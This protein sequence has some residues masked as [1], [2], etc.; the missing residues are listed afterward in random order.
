MGR[1][2]K[3]LAEKIFNEVYIDKRLVGYYSTPNFICEYIKKRLIEIKYDGKAVFDPCCGR[4]EMLVPFLKENIKSYGIDII[5][6]KSS[7]NCC[8]QNMDFIRFFYKKI[9][10]ISEFKGLEYDYYVLNPPYNCHEVEYIRDNRDELKVIFKEVGIHNMYGM[11]IS[12][13]IDLAKEGAVIGIITND[14]FLTEK[15]YKPFREKILSTC[16]IHEITMCPTNL[17]TSQGADV[18][19]SIIILQK[20]VNFQGNIITNNRSIN[21]SELK[22]KLDNNTTLFKLDDI[23]LSNKNDNKEFVINCPID[24]KELFNLDRIASKFNCITGISTGNDKKFLSREKRDKYNIPFYKN[25]GKDRFNTDKFVYINNNFLDISKTLPNFI[26]R[27]KEFLYR[28]G[29]ICSSMGVEFTASRMPKGSTFGVNTAII[30]E[31]TDLFWLL[32]YLNS[33]LVTYFVRGVLLRTNMITSGYVSRIPLLCFNDDEKEYLSKLGEKAYNYSIEKKNIGEILR[34]ID[35]IVNKVARI[36][37]KSISHIIEFKS[38]L[39]K[40]T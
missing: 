32:A 6:Y 31:K 10:V 17:F 38:N 28:E 8:F 24:I 12:A 33:N 22:E 20:G 27:N 21:I 18:R 2:E 40:R 34:S 25:P 13:V 26:V 36:S 1:K 5:K 39:I 14:S 9:N 29:I 7:Y 3:V 19:T 35:S 15:S 11:F 37:D 16:A 4:E 30:C 23:I